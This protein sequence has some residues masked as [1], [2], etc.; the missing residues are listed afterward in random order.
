MDNGQKKQ[1]V[2]TKDT[3]LPIGLIL[4]LIGGVV[5]IEK[6][7]WLTDQVTVRA[8]ENSIEI[9]AQEKEVD[10]VKAQFLEAVNEI[11]LQL[12][13]IKGAQHGTREQSDQKQRRSN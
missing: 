4:I 5:R 10:E 1:V 8:A 9:K 13:E 12:A 11:K 6:I 2:I 7:G 3:L